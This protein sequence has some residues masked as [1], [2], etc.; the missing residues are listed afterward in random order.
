MDQFS[1]FTHEEA[2]NL[3]GLRDRVR[4]TCQVTRVLHGVLSAHEEPVGLGTCSPGLGTG[5]WPTTGE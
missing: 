3:N 5:S 2:E 1:R 4:F